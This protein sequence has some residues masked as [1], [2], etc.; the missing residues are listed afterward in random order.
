MAVTLDGTLLATR[1]VCPPGTRW[2]DAGTYSELIRIDVTSQDPSVATLRTWQSDADQIVFEDESQVIAF[3]ERTLADVSPDGRYVALR[4]QYASDASRWE[5]LDL[6]D[7]SATMEPPTVCESAGD[8]VGTPRFVSNRLVVIARLCKPL[9]T[10]DDTPS[11]GEGE[12]QVEAIDLAAEQP[13]DRIVWN[14][15]VAGLGVDEFTR[16]VDLSARQAPDGTIWAILSGNG[17]IETSSR[18]FALHDGEAI[19]ITR[20]GFQRFAFDPADLIT[21]FD[22]PPS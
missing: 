6:S 14:S 19:D 10:G 1:D 8:I 15:S 16:S 21:E 20:L 11:P 12:V 7:D 13:A 5:L 3:G 9:H 22:A 18:T 17:G 2:G 4:E